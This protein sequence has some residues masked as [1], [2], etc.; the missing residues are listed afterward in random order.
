MPLTVASGVNMPR[1]CVQ[2][3]LGDAIARPGAVRG[4]RDGAIPRRALHG[5][6][7]DR[8]AAVAEAGCR[9][10]APRR[11][12]RCARTCTSTRPS[13][14]ARA[15]SPRTSPRP[16]RS[17]SEL[18]VRGPRRA[19]TDW[20]PELREAVHG[21]AA[22]RPT[23]SSGCG[24]EA[25]LLDTD[26]TLDLPPASFE[27]VDAIYAADHQVPLA[28]GPHHPREVRDRDR[29]RRAEAGEVLEAIVTST[30]AAVRRP[31][32]VVIAHLFSV[33][34]KIGLDEGDVPP[35]LVEQLAA[36][37]AARG[38]PRIEIGERWRCPSARTLRPFV[39]HGR[40]TAGQHRQPPADTIGR[41]DV[42]RR[43]RRRAVPEPGRRPHGCRAR[44]SGSSSA[45][46]ASPRRCPR[47]SACYQF[48][49]AACTASRRSRTRRGPCSPRVAIV[50]PA[51]NEGAVIGRT[52]DYLLAL[53]YPDDAAAHLRGRRRQHRRDAGDRARQGRGAPR[54]RLSP[55]ARE[56]RRGQGAHDQPRPA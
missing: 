56:G 31:E 18:D 51:W 5:L 39:D 42:L 6:R 30:A 50:I 20:V 40:A 38:A 28:D 26:G 22:R 7:R 4:D 19:S 55:P 17:G 46:R 2:Q 16:R 15:R 11:D 54:A 23:S 45:Y 47:W 9:A 41:Y 36:A 34:P 44:R 13:P 48:M 14:T 29:E 32:N 3:A 12:D 49:L 52:I 27:G 25:K 37:A 35:E 1:L 24:I 43:S 21:R 8:G 53:E 33:L 10:H